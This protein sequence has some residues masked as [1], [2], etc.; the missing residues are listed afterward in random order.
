[1]TIYDPATTSGPNNQRMPFPGNRFP[2]RASV[3]PRK[4]VQA[5]Y[6]LPQINSNFANYTNFGSVED[7]NY[8]YDIK[9]D[10]N[11]SDNDKFF[12]RYSAARRT[13]SR[14]ALFPIR[15]RADAIPV[16]S[17]SEPIRITAVRPS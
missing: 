10:H 12:A 1:M 16:S 14:P 17:D 8:E 5:L 13:R 7:D 11:F 6:P 4:N 15:T 9:I 3:R 2:S